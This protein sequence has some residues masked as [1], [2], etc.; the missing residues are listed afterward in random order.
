MIKPEPTTLPEETQRV[1]RAAFPNGNRYMRMRD[2]LG[3][4]YSDEQFAGLFSNLGQPAESP[5]RLALV[6]VM[7][8][9]E[10]LSDR[11][12]ADTLRARID[13]KYALGL[14]LTDTG[15]DYSVFSEFRMRL[16][17]GHA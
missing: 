8:F 11:Q 5:G 12:A 17:A 9:V 16:I 7:Q 6:T 10:G 1:A 14:A 13:W 15:F 3:E 2:T 4:V